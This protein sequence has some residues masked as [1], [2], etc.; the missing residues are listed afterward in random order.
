MSQNGK[1]FVKGGCYQT[2]LDSIPRYAGDRVTLTLEKSFSSRNTNGYEV[3]V[4]I[5][6]SL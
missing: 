5:S 1:I 3:L 2:R 4:A 6:L